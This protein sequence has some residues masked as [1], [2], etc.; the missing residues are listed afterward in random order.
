MV[1]RRI[2]IA[3]RDMQPN[4]AESGSKM[5]YG[6]IERE[7]HVDAS[8]EVVFEV[9]SRPEHIRQWWPDEA[10]IEPTPGAVGQLVW[11]DDATGHAEVVPITVVDVEPPRR[12]SFRWV[13]PEDEVATPSNSLL[14]TF[15]LQPSG[16]GTMVRLT[17]TGF[18]EKGWEAAVLEEQYHEHCV[19]WDWYLPR[20]G[21]YAT[22][23]VS[24]P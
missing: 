17:E 6:S 5:E 13:H 18:R 20:L 7:I 8:P 23:L 16:G 4:V 10:D 24:T 9:V 11:K 19:G 2:A 22:R 3:Y 12:F 1:A 15:E 14:V 21:E